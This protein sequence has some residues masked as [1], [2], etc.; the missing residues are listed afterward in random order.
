MRPAA[1]RTIILDFDGTLVESVGIKDEA[2]RTLFE[3]HPDQLPEIM[4]YHTAHN[5]VL[6]FE[7]FRH[8]TETILGRPYTA[9]DKAQMSQAFYEL[10]LDGLINCPE[11]PGAL[12]FL[13][14]FQGKTP[15][16]LVSKSPDE[17]FDQ[18]IRARDM[19][20]YFARIYAGSWD[21]PDALRHILAEQ[22]IAPDEAVF[23]GDTPEDAAAAAEAG[24][25]FIG[26]RSDRP[27]GAEVTLVFDDMKQIHDH[28]IDSG[29]PS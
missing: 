25:A 17:E 19:H 10:V 13:R 22:G 1:F 9:V 14:R 8:I 21:K 18:V 4:A 7:K 11:V 24:V 28:L 27:F 6:R 23:I 29:D 2:F 20:R 16:Y 15:M 3:D 5:A 26:R 12:D